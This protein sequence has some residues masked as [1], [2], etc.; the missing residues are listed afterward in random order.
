MINPLKRFF[1]FG[2]VFL[3]LIGLVGC[4]IDKPVPITTPI[5]GAP[6]GAW[7]A[8]GQGDGFA[9]WD[10]PFN[11]WFGYY[12]NTAL[13]RPI[14]VTLTVSDGFITEVNIAGP[15]ETLGHGLGPISHIMAVSAPAQIM[16]RNAI[17]VDSVT[18][19]TRTIDGIIQAGEAALAIIVAGD[20]D[21]A[22]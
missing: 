22:D 10:S 2:I 19:S 8:E 1:I 21:R 15:D 9:R 13:G 14:T 4:P 7:R 11:P 17:I 12:G 3:S 18:D 6:A 20:G 5:E 16:E